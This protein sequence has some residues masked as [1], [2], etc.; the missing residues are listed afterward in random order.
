MSNFHNPEE[1]MEVNRRLSNGALAGVTCPK[2]ISDYN[3]WMG[4]VDQ[5]DQKRGAYPSDRR[6]K[7]GWHRIFYHLLDAAIVNAFVQFSAHHETTYLFFRLSLGRR[8]INGQTFRAQHAIIVHKNKK[9]ATATGQ[10]MARVPDDVRFLGQ[11]HHPERLPSRRRCRWCSM[12]QKQ[13]RT[14]YLCSKCQV[15]LCVECFGPFHK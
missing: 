5:Y 3:A 6:S 10:Q 9:N 11:H 13:V 15:P 14:S 8:L 12:A 1:V 4:G 2:A 7:I